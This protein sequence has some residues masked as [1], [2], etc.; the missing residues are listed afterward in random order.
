M[1]RDAAFEAGENVCGFFAERFVPGDLKTIT[2]HA[3]HCATENGA[4][5][6]AGAVAA[7]IGELPLYLFGRRQMSLF[8]AFFIAAE[9]IAKG[10]HLWQIKARPDHVPGVLDVCLRLLCRSDGGAEEAENKEQ[11]VSHEDEA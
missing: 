8:F 4:V 1:H 6:H 3:E 5:F 2:Q 9:V 11:R 10:L 7:R